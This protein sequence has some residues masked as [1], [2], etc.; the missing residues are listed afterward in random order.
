LAPIRTLITAIC[1]GDGV[2]CEARMVR[3][4]GLDGPRPGTEARVSA[5][6]SDDP[7]LMVGQSVRAQRRR[8]SP[9]APGSRSRDGPHWG[10]EILGFVLGSADH[11]RCLYMT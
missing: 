3:G 7:R 1:T 6:E 8:S 9:T 2:L 5:N 11:P 4:R 10:G